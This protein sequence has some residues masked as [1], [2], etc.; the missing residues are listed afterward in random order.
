[1]NKHRETRRS[2]FRLSQYAVSAFAVRI[3]GESPL[4]AVTCFT[5]SDGGLGLVG[6]LFGLDGLGG[7]A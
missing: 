2:S 6:K 3:E 4:G 5:I 7:D 1:M